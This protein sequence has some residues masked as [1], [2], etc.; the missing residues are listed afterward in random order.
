MIFPSN[1]EIMSLSTLSA[2]SSPRKYEMKKSASIKT[3]LGS[4]CNQPLSDSRSSWRSSISSRSPSIL[5]FPLN[6]RG[7]GRGINSMRPFSLLM[8]R[9]R[10]GNS[11]RMSAGISSLPFLSSLTLV[12]LPTLA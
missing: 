12:S 2:S 11:L 8:I 6:V 5:Y 3:L 4:S 10:E 1:A 9:A 7:S